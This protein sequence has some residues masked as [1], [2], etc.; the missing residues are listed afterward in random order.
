MKCGEC[1]ERATHLSLAG[2][3]MYADACIVTNRSEQGFA[4]IDEIE[5]KT[6][7]DASFYHSV[8]LRTGLIRLNGFRSAGRLSECEMLFRKLLRMNDELSDRERAFL[9]RSSDVGLFRDDDT[10]EVIRHLEASVGLCQKYGLLSDEAAGRLALC[11]HLAYDGA[12]DDA[13]RHLNIVAELSSRIWI[14]RYSLLNNQAI[15]MLL[16]G[17]NKEIAVK[18]LNKAIMLATEDGDRLLLL[19]NLLGAGQHHAAFELS[20]LVDDIPDLGEELAKIAHYNLF[21]L[22]ADNGEKGLAQIHLQKAMAMADEPDSDFWRCALRGGLANDQ[23]T[24]LRIAHRYCLTFIVP[25]RLTSHTFK[26]IA[27]DMLQE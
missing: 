2:R 22:Y 18:H 25:W 15:L 14:E 16:R 27:Q 6:S 7:K 24:R 9:L 10:P 8:M 17:S 3:L 4:V 26:G 19:C 21:L 5:A 23:G 20:R 13:Q 12:L 11:Q 1:L